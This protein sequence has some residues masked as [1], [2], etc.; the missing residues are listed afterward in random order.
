M[1][2]VI[3]NFDSFTYNIVHAL[4]PFLRPIKVVQ[5]HSISLEEIERLTPTHIILGP[6]P[7]CPKNAG[8]TLSAIDYFKNKVPMLGI[9]LGHQAIIEAFG[10][11]V[12]RANVAVHGKVSQIYH[13]QEGI[14]QGIKTPF[15][16][17]RY[18]SL[19][20]WQ[21]LA[22]LVVTATL[23]DGTIMGVRHRYAPIFGVQFH[24]ES[25]LSECCQQIFSNFLT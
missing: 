25:I 10:G 12:S 17:T 13:N 7:S 2:V 14:F 9:C 3:D 19:V 15:L 22:P 24:P 1:I 8:I 21:V 18:H 4:Y 20:G 5:S 16:A 6:G 11:R 23:E